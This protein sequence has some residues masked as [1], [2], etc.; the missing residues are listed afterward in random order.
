M[1]ASIP[2]DAPTSNNRKHFIDR[3][4][5]KLSYGMVFVWLAFGGVVLSALEHSAE[6]KRLREYCDA[7]RGID[8]KLQSEAAQSQL[9]SFLNSAANSGRCSAPECPKTSS[10]HTNSSDS[11]TEGI[12]VLTT[13]NG[14]TTNSSEQTLSLIHI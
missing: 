4:R 2:G 14:T 12:R 1:E 11:G 6:E 7:K 10:N 9:S 13:T 8:E 3:H 5:I